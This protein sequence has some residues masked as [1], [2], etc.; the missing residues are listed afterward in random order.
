MLFSAT[1][2]NSVCCLLVS[3]RAA[4]KKNVDYCLLSNDSFVLINKCCS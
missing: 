1:G 2:K 3:L 4:D